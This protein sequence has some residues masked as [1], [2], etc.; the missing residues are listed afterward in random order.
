MTDKING[1]VMVLKTVRGD[2]PIG[3]NCIAEPGIYD[4]YVNPQGAVSV[5]ASNGELLGLKPNEFKWLTG[6][7]EK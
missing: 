7:V 3:H 4:A 2:F 5:R 1:R 6:E